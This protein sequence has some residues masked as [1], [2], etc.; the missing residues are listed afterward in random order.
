MGAPICS[1]KKSEILS[2]YK[3]GTKSIREI[4]SL[5]KIS[6]TTIRSWKKTLE[7]SKEGYFKEM[8]LLEDEK[9]IVEH[10]ELKNSR[11]CDVILDL[12]LESY[13]IKISGEVELS[14]LRSLIKIAEDS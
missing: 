14:L 3:S 2:L 12:S 6:E 1:K 4:S 13:N 11:L 8:T 7:S 5:Y 10:Q 9:K